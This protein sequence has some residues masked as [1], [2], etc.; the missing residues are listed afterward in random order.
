MRI[1]AIWVVNATPEGEIVTRLPRDDEALADSRQEKLK[2]EAGWKAAIDWVNG[3]RATIDW[4]LVDGQVAGS[5][6][7]YDWNN[8]RV[9]M[10]CS[11]KGWILAGGLDPDN[12]SD[13]I[14]TACPAAVDVASG[15]T[16]EGGVLKDPAKVDAFIANVA[17]V[18][19]R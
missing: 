12:V 7:A 14:S 13:A 10:G 19:H 6:E 16:K 4:L 9:P 8:L 11:R 2:G 3:P 17:N 15:V 5:G 18:D 1:K